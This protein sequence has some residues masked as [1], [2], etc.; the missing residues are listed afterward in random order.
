M[1]ARER[2]E[3]EMETAIEDALAHLPGI[4]DLKT[5]KSD[6]LDFKEVSVWGLKAALEAAYRAGRRDEEARAERSCRRNARRA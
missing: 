3:R 4:E 5:R 6:R 2:I 1:T